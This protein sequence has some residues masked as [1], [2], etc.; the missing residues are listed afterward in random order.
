MK[1]NYKYMP[2]NLNCTLYWN[3]DSVWKK[4]DIFTLRSYEHAACSQSNVATEG[5]CLLRKKAQ[6]RLSFVHVGIE[7]DISY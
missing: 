4:K 1:T 5:Q 3:N 2:F 7:N 6:S